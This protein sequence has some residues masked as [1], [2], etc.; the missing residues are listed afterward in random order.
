M[1]EEIRLGRLGNMGRMVVGSIPYHKP[2]ALKIHKVDRPYKFCLTEMLA[3]AVWEGDAMPIREPV[4]RE[5]L[6]A[7]TRPRGQPD[8]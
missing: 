8:E 1:G 6:Q 3:T 7:K 5:E 4:I 2:P